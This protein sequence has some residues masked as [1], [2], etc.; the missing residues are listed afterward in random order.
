MASLRELRV[1][2][3][4]CAVGAGCA[5]RRER[6]PT[7]EAGETAAAAAAR[8]I[9]AAEGVWGPEAAT[10]VAVDE[11]L[12]LATEWAAG[13]EGSDALASTSSLVACCSMDR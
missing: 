10:A 11:L 8:N 2:C 7:T 12:T 13:E 1:R 9:A 3:G 6:G 4:G 5:L